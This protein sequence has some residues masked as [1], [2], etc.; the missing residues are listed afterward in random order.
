MNSPTMTKYSAAFLIALACIISAQGIILVFRLSGAPRIENSRQRANLQDDPSFKDTLHGISGIHISARAV[1]VYD[2]A[3]EQVLYAKDE[4]VPLPLASLTKVMTALVTAQQRPALGIAT[5]QKDDIEQEGD[6]GLLVGEHFSFHD[7]S[8]LTLVG[9]LN[10]GAHALAASVVGSGV[11]FL[12]SPSGDTSREHTFVFLMNQQARRLGLLNTQYRNP[13]GLDEDTDT[14]GG[15]GSA[16]D[17]AYLLAYTIRAYPDLLS[18]TIYPS[19][20]ITSSS[21]QVHTAVNTDEVVTDVPG[22]IGSKTGYTALAGGNLAVIV[23]V[24]IGHP[25]IIVVLGSTTQGRFTDTQILAHAVIA[26][27]G[28]MQK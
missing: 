22:I 12:S 28:D 4:Y 16:R 14:A 7:L 26:T 1:Y 10:D 11:H 25:I 9:S 21:A 13:T 5:I 2:V 15:S 8:N 6:S 17:T 20:K 3:L 18:A 19:I 24:G 27:Y 23:D